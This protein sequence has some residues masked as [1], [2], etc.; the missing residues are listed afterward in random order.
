[1]GSS[2]T[3]SP[4]S[5]PPARQCFSNHITARRGNNIDG[6]ELNA[7]GSGVAMAVSG[8]IGIC[9]DCTCMIRGRLGS[10]RTKRRRMGGHRLLSHQRGQDGGSVALMWWSSGERGVVLRSP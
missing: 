8:S 4:G 3:A 10:R 5:H 6:V 1:M 7:N 9:S 2:V